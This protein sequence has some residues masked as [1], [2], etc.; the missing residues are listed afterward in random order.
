MQ[1]SD[2]PSKTLVGV[3]NDKGKLRLRLPRSLYGGKQ[4]YISLRLDDTSENRAIAEMKARQAELDIKA[5]NFDPTYS[6]YRIINHLSVTTREEKS[7]EIDFPALW[8]LYFNHKASTG[9]GLAKTT[10]S[11]YQSV[12]AL[13]KA[14]GKNIETDDVEAYIQFER[15]R[16]NKG[17][18]IKDRLGL[19]KACG[20]WGVKKKHIKENPFLDALELVEREPLPKADPFRK[21]EV[22]K[23]LAGFIN[24]R[25]YNHY[26]SFVWFLFHTGCRTSEAIG[27]R[28]G[29]ISDDFSDV[30]FK[31]SLTRGVRKETKTG[32]DRHFPCKGSIVEFLKA[33]K[34]ENADPESLVFPAPEGGSIDDHNFSQRAWKKILGREGVRHRVPYNTRHTFI[35]HCLAKGMKLIT[36]AELAGNSPEVILERYA[37]LT[38]DVEVPE[39]YFD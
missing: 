28:W 19:L 25:Y 26:Y 1:S 7:P 24:S 39:L 18:T 11:K 14:Y 20:R 6:R 12:A 37:G 35:S 2:K 30:H 27:L 15:K 33:I 10:Q 23:I 38:E 13:L 34:P 29:H 4:K 3:E 9:K 16:G 31:E 8:T 36:I 5:N 17:G 21:E 32:E 22:S